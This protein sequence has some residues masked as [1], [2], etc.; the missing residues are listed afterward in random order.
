MKHSTL[1]L[2]LFVFALSEVLLAAK[3]MQ[4]RGSVG[5]YF[6]STVLLRNSS[7]LPKC[8]DDSRCDKMCKFFGARGGT[9]MTDA[10]DCGEQNEVI[11]WV[12]KE[13]CVKMCEILGL[14]GGEILNPGEVEGRCW[15]NDCE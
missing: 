14:G 1:Y 10:C 12:K 3:R 4:V 15:C 5:K 8:P 11:D 9:A 7:G 13:N 6:L 2:F